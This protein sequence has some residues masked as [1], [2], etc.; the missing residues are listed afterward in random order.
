MGLKVKQFT[1]GQK[2]KPAKKEYRISELD[3]ECILDREVRKAG[4]IT[5]K[6]QSPS[7][8][9][10]HDRVCIFPGADIWLVEVKA[11]DGRKSVGQSNFHR[12]LFYEV[13]CLR[14][15]TVWCKE[16]VLEFLT[17]RRKI[18]GGHTLK[19]QDQKKLRS[20]QIGRI[21]R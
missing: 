17:L 9:S 7:N 3:V 2:M 5:R 11:P 13:V 6:W 21:E 18:V 16:D 15:I 14:S 19:D 12:Q 10:V 20:L 1:P 8:R 4:G